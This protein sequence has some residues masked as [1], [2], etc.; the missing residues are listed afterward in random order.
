MI[1]TYY[2]NSYEFLR[3][4]MGRMICSRRREKSSGVFARDHILVPSAAVA[5]DLNMYFARS[6][7][8]AT[9]LWF[10]FVGRWLERFTQRTGSAQ[11]TF[12]DDLD[13]M[14]LALINDEAF[15][16]VPAASGSSTTSRGRRRSPNAPSRSASH[17]FLRPT[18]PTAL[19]G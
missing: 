16:I 13:W 5:D 9:G 19:T 3:E 2:S 7:G 6:L 11:G 12:M 1:E 15:L 17:G 4:L 18:R 14:V 10:D 8:V